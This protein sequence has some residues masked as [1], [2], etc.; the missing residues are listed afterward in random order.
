[1]IQIVGG[2][3]PRSCPTSL[4]PPNSSRAWTSLSRRSCLSPRRWCVPCAAQEDPEH[5]AVSLAAAQL[6]MAKKML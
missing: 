4:R 1:M 2:A 5:V 3:A 6:C